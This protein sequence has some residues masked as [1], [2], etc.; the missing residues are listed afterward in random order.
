MEV[1]FVPVAAVFLPPFVDESTLSR[2]LL[3]VSEALLFARPCAVCFTVFRIS[4]KNC[5]WS[6]PDCARLISRQSAVQEIQEVFMM[7]F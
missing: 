2:A 3:V 4:L 5:A 1:P 6:G 7:R